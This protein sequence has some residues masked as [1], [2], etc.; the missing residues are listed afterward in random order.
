METGALC[1]D[2]TAARTPGQTPAAN[3][4]SR[5][6]RWTHLGLIAGYIGVLAVLGW[7]GRG[8]GAPALSNSAGGLILVS[9]ANLA[10]FGC[11]FGLAWLPFF[12]IRPTILCSSAGSRH[13][14]IWP[15]APN[16]WVV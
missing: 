9:A 13:G 3:T 15:E 11:V 8:H 2:T 7:I 6:R 12:A 10:I 16:G 5:L 1:H 14:A 4:V